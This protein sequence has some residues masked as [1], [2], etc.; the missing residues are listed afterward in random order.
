V[1]K[2]W[3]F[4]LVMTVAMSMA[5]ALVFA[6]GQ[7]EPAPGAAAA[8]E[9]EVLIYNSNWSD[10]QYRVADSQVVSMFQ[11]QNPNVKII[12][13]VI[14]DEDFKQAIRAYLQAEPGPDV[15]TWYAGNRARF[16]ISK[17]LI[18]DITDIYQQE[19]W[20]DKYP[21]AFVNL[22][23]VNGKQYFVPTNW[24]WWAVYYRKSVFQKLGL[25]PPKTWDEF[26]T[27][28]DTI[29]KSGMSPL[30]IGTK[31]RWTT[32]GV[33]DYL[34]MR[35]NGPEF[36]L[37][38][39]DGE[40]SY[41]DP[42]VKR[43]F[44]DY[45]APMLKK[46]YFIP[47]A[48]AYTWQEAINLM[49]TGKAAMYLMGQFISTAWP[50]EI[51]DDLDF[52]QFPIIDPKVAIAE[53]A[54]TDGVFA[55]AKAANPAMAKKFLAFLGS[56]PAQEVWVKQL[57]RLATH[58]DVDQSLYTPYQKKGIALINTADT[59]T[60]FYDRDTTPPMADKGMDAFME[61]WANPDKAD[62]IL[63]RLDAQRKEFFGK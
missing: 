52:F 39:C 19:G 7:K 61:F 63:A 45:W 51:K 30:T 23:T 28:C 27:V 59:L 41:T 11:A 18:M 20:Y 60:Q 33:F 42:R 57:G 62:D 54:P 3:I 5:A 9:K 4:G 2:H 29:K 56:A 16:F 22:S 14:S 15:L 50:E 21:K 6:G 8:R 49:V 36:H 47:D 37:S 17:G 40:E 38:L 53:D 43:V 35:V 55:S 13:S 58:K 32:G 31:W 12:H 48:P 26:M 10:A 44:K 46:G 25:T 1:R 24:Y 34:N